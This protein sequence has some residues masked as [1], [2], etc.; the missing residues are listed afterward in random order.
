MKN[1]VS[2]II[3][4]F[5]SEKFIE[6]C[7]DS[8]LNQTYKNI[9]IIIVDDGSSDHTFDI[10]SRY[11][12]S[13]NNVKLI[14]QN[15]LGVM[16]ARM[17]GVNNAT[18]NYVFFV[19]S[20]DW[21]D[22][23]TIEVL[24]HK[25][26]DQKDVVCVLAN[27]SIMPNDF[28]NVDFI[29]KDYALRDLCLLKC[30]VSM[31]AYM[32]PISLIKNVNFEK[33]IHFF[34]DFLFNYIVLQQVKKIFLCYENFYH[35]ELNVNSINHAGL[36]EKRV[37]CM[38]IIP[39]LLENGR[40]YNKNVKEECVFTVSHFLISNIAV[41]SIKDSKKLKLLVK[42]NC[43][44]YSKIIRKSKLVSLKSKIA[45]FIGSYSINII[46]ILNFI[47]KKINGLKCL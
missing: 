23:N 1:R 14:H 35:Y 28:N 31:C 4:A 12:D 27:C 11:K 9:E 16:T 22:K 18:G 34:E 38:K 19:D 26:S 15:N 2:I 40:F 30:P 39:D 29:E 32:Y 47:R 10:C 43:K 25:M 33:E 17:N 46:A 21:I 44:R 20:D 45:I 3:P 8:V 13:N 36:N 6:R 24:L 37:S 41:L 5:N 7:I 42:E